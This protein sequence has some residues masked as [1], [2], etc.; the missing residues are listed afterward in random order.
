MIPFVSVIVPVYN[1]EKYLRECLDSVID[2]SLREIEIICVDDGSTDASPAVLAEYAARD[3]RVRVITQEN[4]GVGPARNA[5]IR[6][7]RGEF[8][9]FIDPDDLLPD[10]SAYEALYLWAKE[11]R[12]RV[13]GGGV[14]SLANDG[15]RYFPDASWGS[16]VDQTFPR[17]GFMRF[18]E[19]QF[20]YGFYRYIFER[21]L[22][23][24]NEIFFPPYIRYQDPVFCAR[25]AV[26]LGGVPL[27]ATAEVQVVLEVE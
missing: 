20:D 21:R 4:A 9:A 16:N 14:C 22:L 23:L 5:G 6:A 13:C 25:A 24:D 8:V 27:H 19:W 10:E 17:D 11:K 3:S 18:A 1:A 12:V 2:Q 7:A 26:A 15:R